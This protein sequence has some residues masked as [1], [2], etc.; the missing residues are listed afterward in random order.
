MKKHRIISYCPLLLAGILTAGA[1]SMATGTAHA[2]YTTV[3]SSNLQLRQEAPA[4]VTLSSDVM[5]PGGQT[6]ELGRLEV[7]GSMALTVN[8]KAEGGTATGALLFEEN[9]YLTGSSPDQIDGAEAEF[10]VTLTPTQEAQALTG[11]LTTTMRMYWDDDLWADLR[12]TLVPDGAG[13]EAQPGSTDGTFLTGMSEF[14]K[15]E[16]LALRIAAPEGSDTI[17]LGGLP[18][19]TR[20]S[21]DGETFTLLYHGG[22]AELTPVGGTMTVLLDLEGAELEKDL[23]LTAEAIDGEASLG[24]SALSVTPSV[25]L[26]DYD[27]SQSPLIVGQTALNLGLPTDVGGAELYYTLTRPDGTVENMPLIADENGSLVIDPMNNGV[28]A[29]AGTYLLEINWNYRGVTVATRQL[30]FYIN[31]CS[32]V[33]PSSIIA[34]DSTE[35]TTTGGNES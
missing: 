2:R 7:S 14:D 31:Y 35:A 27:D 18:E 28:Q 22:S 24:G 19:M 20:Y 25:T 11:E 23:T 4:A 33:Q 9:P 12:V 10:D 8:L 26:M 1:L 29:A 13:E 17:V 3:A 15:S 30:T 16:R 32:Y 21:T 5:I 34:A 6:V